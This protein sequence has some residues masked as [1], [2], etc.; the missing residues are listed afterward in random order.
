MIFPSSSTTSMRPSGRNSMAVGRSK[1]VAS[2]SFWNWA[3]LA[4][5]T[6][7]AVEMVALAAASRARA[8]IRCDPLGS[9][10]VSQA[11]PYGAVSSGPVLMSST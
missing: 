11:S 3:V 10:R 2:T 5:F 4:T 8:V 7:T 9:V 6:L 1:P